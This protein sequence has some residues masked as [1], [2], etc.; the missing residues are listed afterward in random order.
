MHSNVVTWSHIGGNNR[1][2]GFT[3]QNDNLHRKEIKRPQ[4]DGPWTTTKNSKELDFKNGNKRAGDTYN[5]L[6]NSTLVGNKERTPS[7]GYFKMTT[8]VPPGHDLTQRDAPTSYRPGWG[9]ALKTRST[10][11]SNGDTYHPQSG[12]KYNP[13][14]GYMKGDESSRWQTTAVRQNANRQRHWDRTKDR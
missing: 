7:G 1:N 11:I 2:R 12:G 4:W 9:D 13:A 5:G 3:T 8:A 10:K 6:K 14:S